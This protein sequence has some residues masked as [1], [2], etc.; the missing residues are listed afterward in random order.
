METVYIFRGKFSIPKVQRNLISLKEQFVFVNL[1]ILAVFA[2]QILNMILQSH[3]DNFSLE[4]IFFLWWS[5]F[6]AENIGN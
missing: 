6:Y 5:K 4:D 3:Y 1:I 2:D